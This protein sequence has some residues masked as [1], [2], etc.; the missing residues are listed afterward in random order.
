MPTSF[1]LLLR[2]FLRVDKVMVR[3]NDTRV[4]HEF[5]K[6]YIIREYTSRES[7]MKELN[8]PLHMF[9]DPNILSSHVPLRISKYEKL[10]WDN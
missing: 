4:F 10:T 6:N 7:G 3:L 2:Y 8:L 9:T 1:F 5:E